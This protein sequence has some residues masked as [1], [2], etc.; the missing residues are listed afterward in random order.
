MAQYDVVVKA[1]DQTRGTFRNIENGLKNIESVAQRAQKILAGLITAQAIKSFG[2]AGIELQKIERQL[3]LISPVGTNVRDLFNGLT[4]LSSQLG[5]S[6]NDLANA[7]ISLRNNGI[8]PSVDSLTNLSNIA[9]ASGTSVAAIADAIGN[10]ADGERLKAL[11]NATNGL[12]KIDEV[13]NQ[14]GQTTGQFAVKYQGQTVAVVNSTQQA[15]DAINRIGQVNLNKP[16]Q[17]TDTLTKAWE[18]FKNALGEAAKQLLEGGL[19]AGLIRV[20]NKATELTQKL[21]PLL[22][23]LGSDLKDA[24]ITATNALDLLARGF[25]YLKVVI[26]TYLGLQIAQAFVGLAIV[27]SQAVMALRAAAL[28]T[29]AVGVAAAGATPAVV[30][31]GAALLGIVK[32]IGPLRL[33]A[34]AVAALGAGYVYLKD[35]FGGASDAAAENAAAVAGTNAEL[36]RQKKLQ[37]DLAK[38]LPGLPATGGL[39]APTPDKPLGTQPLNALQQIQKQ[40]DEARQAI[41]VL[42]PA[43]Q[44]ALDTG[45]VAEYNRIFNA[46]KS[47][48]ET[49]GKTTL[50]DFGIAAKNAFRDLN[51]SISEDVQ[52]LGVLEANLQTVIN[53]F[54]EGSG[55][56]SQYKD[57]IDELR[58]KFDPLAE[59][60][61]TAADRQR[62]YDIE[63]QN[64]NNSLRDQAERLNYTKLQQA[65]YNEEIQK[66]ILSLQDQAQRLNNNALQQ[67][68]YNTEIEKGR[69]ALQDQ[70]QRLKDGNLQQALFNQ[71][72]QT[73]RNNLDQQRITL[74][75]LNKA[76]ADGKI[77]L[78]EYSDGLSSVN[79][80][81]LSVDQILARTNNQSLNEIDL[82]NKKKAALDKLITNYK[83]AG[84]VGT[85]AFRKSAEALGANATQ[86]DLIV[87]QYGSFADLVKE[88]NDAIKKSIVDASGTFVNEFTQA[89]LQGKNVLD[90]FKNF[91]TNV[92]NSIAAEIIKQQIAKPIASVL[93]TFIQGFIPGLASGGLAEA[94]RPYIVG[95]RG[96][97]LFVPGRSGTV[98]PND[99]L[100]PGSMAMGGEA[101]LTVNFTINAIDTQTGVQFL[102]ENK[103][104][105]TSMISDAYNRRGRRGPLD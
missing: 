25:D 38:G 54:G 45:N 99:Q 104:V 11:E 82:T 50:P 101:P 93:G 49:V 19:E 42:E 68:I 72:I 102:I 10:V 57:Q 77:S 70:A 94:N 79:E 98:V 5:V 88:R 13:L 103:P 2:E 85:E 86:I 47:N 76:Y 63:I 46:L 18:R 34:I 15:L 56:V 16:T 89:F 6:T 65:L 81:L 61:K 7:Y 33:V 83:E 30:G 74:E 41:A 4:G 97:E 40:T 53:T 67:S 12:I 48:Y 73:T 22:S 100:V 58:K 69:L 20:I 14:Y 26:L 3:G 35:K 96:P 92:L 78:S 71:N 87:A 29:A 39:T 95:E 9:K 21:T 32:A 59:S 31:L 62:T 27:I 75:L 105:I 8:Q 17:E 66:N 24:L 44:R 90:S 55:I 80:K 37:E 64:I 51:Q 91:F 1:V 43:L 36:E 28:G 52:K 60:I 84:G 23:S